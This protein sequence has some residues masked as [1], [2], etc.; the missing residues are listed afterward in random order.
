MRKTIIESVASPGALS[1]NDWMN[2]ESVA[3]VE[4]SSEDGAHP[5]ES[6]LLPGQSRGW[7][8]AGPGR[9]VIRLRFDHPQRLRH[10]RLEFSE[11]ERERT[12]EYT[13]R[14][15]PDG[16]QSFRE[17]VRQ[18]YNFSPPGTTHECEDFHCNLAGVSVLE[19]NIVPDISG[20][21]SVASMERLRIA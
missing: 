12:Q 20:G 11:S 9:Q 6:A 3:S 4:I 14:W 18:Q 19:I 1:E 10:I 17:V 5:I 7:R 15:S 16:G 13:L 2:I 8:A 21:S